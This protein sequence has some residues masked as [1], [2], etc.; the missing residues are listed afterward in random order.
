MKFDSI[1]LHEIISRNLFCFAVLSNFG[2]APVASQFS[3]EYIHVSI[4]FQYLE[5]FESV[6]D[7][8]RIENDAHCKKIRCD[9]KLHELVSDGISRADFVTDPC[10][11]S[12]RV[13]LVRKS[14]K[15]HKQCLAH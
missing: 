13:F 3:H 11:I 4:I 5:H 15:Q 12:M 9:P 7:L 10:E 14:K 1:T 2:V 6:W 8:F